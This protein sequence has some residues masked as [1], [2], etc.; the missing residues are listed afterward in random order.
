[1]RFEVGGRCKGRSLELHLDVRMMSTPPVEMRGELLGSTVGEGSEDSDRDLELSRTCD[2]EA[3]LL[4]QV[5]KQVGRVLVVVDEDSHEGS[6]A[7]LTRRG[8][9]LE[10]TP[11]TVAPPTVEGTLTG[12]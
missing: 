11:V 3:R 8:R 2:D 4:T 1:M 5:G 6:S 7:A 12:W 10:T 9:T